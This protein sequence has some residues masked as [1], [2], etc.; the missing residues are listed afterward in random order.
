MISIDDF[1][2]GYFS[3]SYLAQLPVDELK[4]DKSFVIGMHKDGK[5]AA[6]VRWITGLG[7]VLGLR[8]VAEWNP[9]SAM[10]AATRHLFGNPTAMPTNPPWPL[11][12]S[13]LA[14]VLWCAVLLAVVIPLTIRQYA[15]RT[16]G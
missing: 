7:H 5:D 12:H 1:R 15:A 10:S 13:V 16:A 4:I 11:Q 2:S 8:V 6:I 3:L 14:S 9:F